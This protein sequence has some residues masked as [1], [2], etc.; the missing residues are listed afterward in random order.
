[1]QYLDTG[2][3]EIFFTLML[4]AFVLINIAR[5]NA[6]EKT[7]KELY[8]RR[9]AGLTAIDEA[10]GRATEMGKPVLMVPGLSDTVD[11]IAVQAL[12]IFAYV[13]RIAA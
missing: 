10:V 9:I 6:S 11:A 2:W 3:V 13:T 8:I 4:V 12:N 5:A 7:G 1:M